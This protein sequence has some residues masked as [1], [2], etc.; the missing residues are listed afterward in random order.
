MNR[1][2]DFATVRLIALTSPTAR[3]PNHIRKGRD[4]LKRL[5]CTALYCLTLTGPT[6]AED[7]LGLHALVSVG[8]SAPT[9]ELKNGYNTG[10]HGL[11]GAVYD[12]SPT[13]AILAKLEYH[14]FS[15]DVPSSWGVTGGGLTTPMFGADILLM[16]TIG[17]WSA[18]PMITFGGGITYVSFADIF[19]NDGS[20]LLGYGHAYSYFDL[21]GGLIFTSSTGPSLFIDARYLYIPT[22]GVHISFVPISVG[23]KFK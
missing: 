20:A 11:L 16:P 9:D 8:V 13:S 19:F 12:L 3:H 23:L 18:R 15:L 4:T 7:R 17:T 6:L 2:V 21:G 5:L 10:L 14:Y 22:S 1:S